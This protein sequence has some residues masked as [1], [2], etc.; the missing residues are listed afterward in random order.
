VAVLHGKQEI[1]VES[2]RVFQTENKKVV[3]VLL[4]LEN[5]APCKAR[6]VWAGAVIFALATCSLKFA[7]A[8]AA[9]LLQHEKNN[10]ADL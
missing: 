3:L 10:S 1:P 2:A 7:K 4:P 6:W 5:R 8:S 9:T